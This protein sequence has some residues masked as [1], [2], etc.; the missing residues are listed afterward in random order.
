M[1]ALAL[2]PAAQSDPVIVPRCRAGWRRVRRPRPA[3]QPGPRA[4]ALCRAEI[5]LWPL[6]WGFMLSGRSPVFVDQACDGLA[7]L[8]PGSDIDGLI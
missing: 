2:I 6:S 3:A 4:T 5:G 8:D 1:G 7:A